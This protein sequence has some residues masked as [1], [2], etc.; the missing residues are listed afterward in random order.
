MKKILLAFLLLTV[1]APLRLAAQ[2]IEWGPEIKIKRAKQ[3]VMYDVLSYGKDGIFGIR[4]KEGWAALFSSVDYNISRYDFDN[5]TMDDIH[6]L[7]PKDYFSKGTTEPTSL[8]GVY[9]YGGKSY[10]MYSNYDSKGKMNRAYAVLLDDNYEVSGD[11]IELDE[12]KVSSKFSSGS[13][14]FVLSE[15]TSRLLVYFMPAFKMFESEKFKFNIF[16]TRTMERISDMEISLPKK[17]KDFGL[18]DLAVTPDNKVYMLAWENYEKEEKKNKTKKDPKYYYSFYVYDLDKQ[19]AEP[20]V[21]KIE[22]DKKFINKL[23]FEIV[24]DQIV[25]G[26]FYGKKNSSDISGTFYMRMS[27]LDGKELA[28]DT[29]DFDKEFISQFYSE[30]QMQRADKKGKELDVPEIV[31]RDFI[32]RDDGGALLIGEQYYIREVCYMDSRGNMRC[33]YY[34]YYNDII[35]TN[36]TPSGEIEW[37]V[38]IP[39]KS[40]DTQGGYFLGYVMGYT[41]RKL[42]FFFNDHIDNANEVDPDKVK[43]LNNLKKS[44][45]VMVTV[46]MQGKMDKEMLLSQEKMKYYFKPKASTWIE[47]TK[48]MIFYCLGSSKERLGKFTF[49]N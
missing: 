4:T 19:D 44:A 45:I 10:V 31:L 40:V 28:S 6:S 8:D 5:L 24:D 2:E 42:Y 30:K 11:P 21:F 17:D 29:Y 33:I 38:K 37:S 34:Y 14:S 46:D 49:P 18:V 22:L 23:E 43:F 35:V 12:S 20:E 15:D 1:L 41:D 25:I 3:G 16:D 7:F 27:R 32:L 39:K 13:Y 48:D 47:G 36:I 26:G 9:H